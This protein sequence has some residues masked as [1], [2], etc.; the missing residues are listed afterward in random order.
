MKPKNTTLLLLFFLMGINTVFSQFT[1]QKPDLRLC[2]SPPN[3]YQGYFNCDS[4]NYTLNQVFL[5]LTDQNGVPLSNTTCTPGSSRQMYVML[6]YTSNA[7]SNI[8]QTRIFADLSIDGTIVPINAYL[9]TV[10]PGGGQRKIYGPFTWTCGQELRLC[11][12]LAVWQP[13]GGV[14][15]PE[16]N[17]YNC[18]TYSKSQCEFGDCMIV[19]A[20]LAVEYSYTVCTTGNQ[21]TVVFQDLTSGGITPYSYSW[22]FGDGSP[23]STQ[24]NPTHN[25]PYPGGPYT[26]TLT[27]TDSNLPNNLVSTY[28]QIITPPAP[29]TITGQVTSASCAN[30]NNGAI[31]ATVSGGTTPYTYSWSNG[32]TTQDISGLAPG[33][34]TLTVTDAFGCTKSQSFIIG[35]G[36]TTNPVI[37]APND[38]SIEGCGTASIASEGY[39]A[40]ST[41][42][43]SITLAQFTAAGG[44]YTDASSI[45]SITYQDVASGSCPTI[46]TRTFILTDTCGNPGSDTQII[47]IDDTTPPV[48]ATLPAVSTINCPNTPQ[49]AQATATDNCGPGF[50]LT[51]NDVT[52]PGQCTGAYSVTRTWTA[53]DT[54][55]NV[56]TA[57]QTI[58]VQDATAPVIAALPAAS[59]I[60][61][62]ATPQF[63]EATATDA[64]GSEFT[65]TFN[66]VT[67]P[68]QC[69]GSYS[70]TRTW[71]ALDA[72]GNSSTKSQ[73][74]NVQ[75]VTAPVIAALPASSTINCPAV[76]QFAEATAT[77]NCGS[78]FTLTFNDVTTPGQCAGSYSV[79]RTWTASDACGN[80]STATQ[81]INVQDV[82]APV[83][84]DLPPTSTINC[85]AVPQFAQATATDN[86]GS[87]FTLTFNDVTTPGQCAGSYSV[88][89]T[90]TARDACGNSSTKSQTINVQDTTAPVIAALPATSTINCPAV[91]QFTQATATDNCGSAFTLTFNDVTTPGQ[92]AGSYS[93]TRTWTARD[94]CGNSST[95]TQTINVQDITAPVIAALPATSTINC[96]ATP[97]FA[98]ATATDACGSAFTLTYN[99]VTTPGTCAGKYSVTRTWTATDAC[100]NSSTRSQTIN[101]QDITPPVIPQAPA[102][103]TVSCSGDIPPMISLTAND[104]CSGPI[105]VPGT[106][107]I[108]AGSCSS[109]YTVTRRWTFVD[110]CGNTSSVSQIINVSDRSNPVLETPPANITVSCAGEV[111][112]MISLTATDTCAGEITVLGVDT[113]AP[114]SCPNSYV[115]TRRWTVADP[116]GN[117]A[118]VSQ[119]ITVRDTTP[120]V[121][122]PLPATST[123]DCPAV[124]QFAQ[125]T[126]TDN[127]GSAFTLTFNDVTT[128]GQCAGSYS[129]TRTWTARD[130]C[131]NSST[132]TQTINVQDVTAPVIADLPAASTI[133]CPA[134]PQFAQATATD[135]CGSVF[136]LT[137][138]DV[139]T[140]GQCAG[141]Y[142]VTRTWTARDA[143][144][145][146]STKS[147]T[148]NVQDVTAPVIAALPA[149]STINCPAVPQFSQAT[150]T[151]ACGST[152]TLTFNDVTTPGQC[153]GSYSVTRTWTATDTC[154]NSSTKSQTINVQDVTA[155]VIAALPATSTINCPAVPQFAQAT[156]TDACGSVFT[157][158]FNDVTTPGSCAGKYSVTR[159]WTATDAC[160]N[161]STRS[162]TI[163]VQDITS[164]VIPQAPANVTVSCSG[165][166]PPMISL[167][168]TDTCGGP[169][170]VT[171]TDAVT[172]G[173]CSSSFTVTRTWTFVDACGNTSSVN[174]TINVRDT[175]NPVLP[176][177]PADITISCAGEVPPMV[178]LTASDTCAGQITVLGVDTA[179]PG[180]CPSSY[181]ITRRWIFADPCG[182]SAS[183][184]QTITVRDTTPPVIDPLPATATIDCKVQPQFA[185]ATATDNCILPVTFTFVD[186]TTPGAC[187]GSY[188]VT[189]TWTATD[190]CQN[191]SSLSQ[192]IVVEDTTPPVFNALPE[193]STIDCTQQPQFAQPQAT[194]DCSLPIAFTFVDVTTP[195]QCAGSY[196]VTRTW[197]AA[198]ACGNSATSSQTINI[199]DITPPVIE[200][201]PGVATINCPAQP[202]FVQAVATDNCSLPI[203]FTF[204]DVTAPGACDGSY[205]VTR[206]WTAKDACGNTSTASQTINVQ[207]IDAPVS[208]VAPENITVACTSEVPP[209]ITLSATDN[210]RGDITVEGIDAVTPGVCSNSYTI[211]RTW[212]FRD[213]CDNTSSVSQTIT[214]SDIIPPALPEVPADLTVS[215][216]SEVPS[217]LSLTAVDN[218]TGNITAES[219]DTTVQGDCPNSFVVTR[220]WTFTDACNN[221]NSMSQIITVFDETPP[222]LVKNIGEEIEATCSNIPTPL[223]P[224]FADNC[225][226]DVT[227]TY[228]EHVDPN[229]EIEGSYDIIRTWTATDS[230]DNST[231][232]SQTVHVTVGDTF[233]ADNPDI[234]NNIPA[235]AAFN[236]MS[237]LPGGTEPGGQ[238]V[239]VNILDA[240]IN[241]EN[242]TLDVTQLEVGYY[243]LQYILTTEQ[244]TCPR[245]LEFYVHVVDN[246]GVLAECDINVYNG[247]SPNN[248]GDNDILVIQG[249]ECYAENKVQI[250]N[251]WGILVFEKSGYNN[252]TVVFDGKSEGRATLNKGELL[253]G[254]TYFYILKYKDNEQG[255]W[256]DK[257]GYLYLSR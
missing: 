195:G 122:S 29:I 249:L 204:V 214:V 152:F 105:A 198:D 69:A 211:V 183:V 7:N 81:T 32:Q 187:T 196:S 8:S 60:N 102:N 194:D 240:L 254:G 44:S 208:R 143:C 189:R 203:T 166:I 206:T 256:H 79:T 59:T 151:D 132:K 257:S 1:P 188:S 235:N 184:S 222:V 95:A 24:Q 236:L 5:S 40:Y 252:T 131:G 86:C 111:P 176:T 123:I 213:A 78:A 92:C 83:I 21:S 172:A 117:S 248:D 148:I 55:G 175:S 244:T 82:A 48:I 158:T 107:T 130:V 66:D 6:N 205:S 185:Q 199:Q 37:T 167:T 10:A 209:M 68:G 229:S 113:I 30:Q 20:P 43:V 179:A 26:V 116:C 160:G 70:V 177:P 85:P 168:A 104:A 31:D 52:T 230:C 101:V 156:A 239:G 173:S 141:S 241:H 61:C 65:L 134:V 228:E 182:N 145:N 231:V 128:P 181:V 99:D 100:G 41:T 53:T 224:E 218:C 169:I 94:A 245:K 23:I 47:T 139:T 251:R 165:D 14:N 142:S 27:V 34:Y 103:V 164:P 135:N 232:V 127:C 3:Y 72:C 22:N 96:P 75:D 121:I 11:R 221:T 186:I 140:P 88:T 190:A 147:Q 15:D 90:W 45:T 39:L 154:G 153:A 225:G 119:T 108:T 210:C 238:W 25:F 191:T 174:Q 54:C 112:P 17:S 253:P 76:P 207:D 136:T 87:A 193:V 243:T 129:V 18:S 226:G 28:T 125:A 62:P 202:E 46:V 84:A 133:N 216:A 126:A 93:V 233:N 118:S 106:D 212:T 146:S 49:F 200:T 73:T 150:A 16:L 19:A 12:I 227:V 162:Q 178:S 63:A 71:T 35:N 215:C 220:T 124:P 114:G 109:S 56:S 42:P 223:Q 9:G 91:P 51:H 67:T 36:D 247:F 250:Y 237:L 219:V 197:T 155:P 161:S 97:Q 234:C 138:K 163:N 217:P 64:C 38:V 4:N 137:F 144:G 157:L 58:N 180:N 242:N 89:R 110:A 149:T 77:D 115:I 255:N 57:T 13:N 192:T 33:N 159:T 74:I 120:P 50:T 171:G 246:C 2:G 80:S 170:T 98:Q 201:L